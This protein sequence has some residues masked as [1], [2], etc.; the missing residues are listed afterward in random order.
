[1]AQAGSI[2]TAIR[3]LMSRGGPSK[4]TSTARLTHTG[5]ITVLTENVPHPIYA[6]ADPDGRADHLKKVFAALHGYLAIIIGDPAQNIPGG[7]L[8]YRYLDK[9]F[10]DVS[11]DMVRVIRNAVEEMR[12]ERNW[13][14]P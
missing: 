8:D 13:R 12:E 6:G 11:T 2:T 10:Q 1:M 5:L 14:A 3:Q 4:S 7:A 9:L